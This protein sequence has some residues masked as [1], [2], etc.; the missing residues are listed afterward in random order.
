MFHHF[1][2]TTKTIQ[3]RP[4]V[5]SVNCS[6]F[7]QLCCTTDVISH[8]SRNFSKFGRQSLVM[9]NCAWNFS[10][11]ETEKYFEWRVIHNYWIRL[12]CDM[13]NYADLGGCSWSA[14][15]DSSHHTKAEFNNCWL[16]QINNQ[17]VL[18]RCG[19]EFSSVNFHFPTAFSPQWC[20]V[21]K[22]KSKSVFL[23]WLS[24]VL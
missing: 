15:V 8:M 1:V 2:L 17:P 9:L 24:V 23:K 20:N 22:T 12:S 14:S 6:V 21:I 10:Q 18:L 19:R 7:W 5:F 3:P 4:Q 13:K 16:L 11:S